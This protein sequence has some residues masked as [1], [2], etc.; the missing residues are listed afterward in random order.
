MENSRTE[1]SIN[2]FRR[3]SFTTSNC[4]TYC[5]GIFHWSVFCYYPQ[6]AYATGNEIFLQEGLDGNALIEPFCTA[7]NLLLLYL[8]ICKGEPVALIPTEVDLS[9]EHNEIFDFR[10]KYLP[11]NQAAYHTPPKVFSFHCQPYSPASGTTF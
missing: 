8:K 1:R 3:A 4:K 10:K 7:R 11:T 6:Q 2:F 5:R 9:Y